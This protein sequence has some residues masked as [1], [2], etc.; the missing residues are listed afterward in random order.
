MSKDLIYVY[1]V[2]NKKVGL[3][4]ILRSSN[5]RILKLSDFYIV[6]KQ[7]SSAEFSEENFRKSISDIKWL[8]A[9]AREH[10]F[11]IQAFMAQNTVIPFNFGTIFRNE[12]NLS[13]FLI[14][15]SDSLIDNFNRIAGMEE[16]SIK[17]YCNRNTLSNK[18]VDLSEEL[19]ALES[20]IRSSPPGTAFLKKKKK[21]DIIEKEMDMV[22][23]AYGQEYFE[24]L[25]KLSSSIKLN[26][27]VPSETI[28]NE[29]TM[30]L[31]ASFLVEKIFVREFIDTVVLL[32]KRDLDLGFSIEASGP[33][34]PFSFI[35]IKEKS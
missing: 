28:G 34:P 5:I 15:Y 25:E 20:E 13:R 16:W 3:P 9:N 7:V 32:R 11:V 14:D 10:V 31:N 8:D 21:I 19:A 29:D 17:F 24:S 23:Q 35:S 4:E 18:M 12:L 30:A 1:C 22:C 2:S 27:L 6:G 26:K 33:W